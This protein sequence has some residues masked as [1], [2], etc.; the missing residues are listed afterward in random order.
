MGHH[1]ANPVL[2]VVP[3][4]TITNW[5]RE[6]ERWAPE[7]RVVPFYGEAKARDIIKRY[8][9]FHHHQKPRTTGAKFHVLV[10]T[11][12]M[13]TNPREFTPVFKNVP[14]WE[15]LVVDE[16]QRRESNLMCSPK[17]IVNGAPVKSDD[18][19]I[20]KKLK[21]LNT[22]HRV[23]MTGVSAIVCTSPAW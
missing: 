2:V 6:F 3:N 22:I 23:I 12:E 14:R 11:Y 21:E 13:I 18:S 10:T 5:V 20:F 17:V 4:S 19:M 8:E 1:Q 15:I 9:L 16:G 7:L